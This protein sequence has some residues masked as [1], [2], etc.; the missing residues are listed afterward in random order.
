MTSFLINIMI[1]LFGLCTYLAL[2]IRNSEGTRVLVTMLITSIVV[3]LKVL[4]NV[5]QV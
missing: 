1:F 4:H 5:T 3:L 2:P